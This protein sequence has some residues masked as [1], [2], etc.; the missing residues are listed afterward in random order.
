[1]SAM[2]AGESVFWTMLVIAILAI[3]AIAKTAT[4]VPQQSAFIVE[5]LGRYSKTLHAGFHILI[6][7]VERIAYKHS[8]KEQAIDIPE[9]VCITRDNVQVGIDGV[10]YLQVLDARNASY[11]ITNYQF[12]I[13]QLAQTT[14]RSEIGKI[15]LDRTFEERS[16]INA[17]VVSELD[18]A[19]EPWGAKVLRY[20]IRNINPPQDVLS[21][22]EKQ[23]R[24]E[25]EKRAVILTS[26]GVRD[27][28][29]N[30]AE[31][32]KQRVIKESEAAKQQQINEAEGEAQAILAVATATAE[33]LRQV[34]VAVSAQG[35]REAMQLRVAEDYVQQFGNLAKVANTLIVPANLSD[36]ASMIALAT[37]V[38]EHGS[39]DRTAGSAE[40]KS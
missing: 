26:E 17:N 23:M 35:G 40:Q 25:R 13:S 36:V 34:A 29:I 12:A 9:Q 22:M 19:S 1:M 4:V 28:K 38:F 14:L 15:D 33:G 3:I 27:A 2:F 20:E 30:Q 39:V 18:K 10:L 24:A 31:G 16:T 5:S 37:K 8:L 32:E 7:F 11:G 21:A 6:P